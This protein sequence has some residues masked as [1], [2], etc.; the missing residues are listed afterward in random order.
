MEVRSVRHLP[1][2]VAGAALA[3]VFL[4][5]GILGF[6]PGATLGYGDIEVLGPGSGAMMFGLF[7]VSLLHNAVH[8]GFGVVGLRIARTVSGARRYLLGGGAIAIALGGYGWLVDYGS[9]AN[10]LPA[11]AADNWLHFGLGVVMVVSGLVAPG[12]ERAA[13]TRATAS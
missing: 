1:V 3:G 7:A 12:A 10:L 4:A 11:N 13:G 5:L 6:V 2:Q 8:L 9:G